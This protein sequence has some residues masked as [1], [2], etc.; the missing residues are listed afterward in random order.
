MPHSA[1]LR[2][3]EL[4]NTIC[5]ASSYT[6]YDFCLRSCVGEVMAVPVRVVTDTGVGAHSHKHCQ[7][8]GALIHFSTLLVNYIFIND[9]NENTRPTL[10]VS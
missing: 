9:N 4:V 3:D 7:N 1:L 5:S 6:I 10:Y 2:S 8:P